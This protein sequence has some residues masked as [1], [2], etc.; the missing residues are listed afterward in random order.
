M[1][2]RKSEVEIFSGIDQELVRKRN[3][4]GVV[5]TPEIDQVESSIL[6]SGRERHSHCSADQDSRAVRKR[7]QQA[8]SVNCGASG[9]C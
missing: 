5:G 9:W 3:L 1:L 6:R 8:E 4:C 7:R 2:K